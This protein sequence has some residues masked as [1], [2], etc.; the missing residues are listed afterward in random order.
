MATCDAVSTGTP[1]A[2]SPCSIVAG[3]DDA[4]PAIISE[5]NRPIDSTIPL[6]MNVARIP[7][8]AP[9]CRAGTA[10]MMPVVLGAANRPE[11]IPLSSSRAMKAG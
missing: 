6:F 10:F 2:T 9:R 1:L 7:D 4:S 8:A 11:P 3:R 5:K